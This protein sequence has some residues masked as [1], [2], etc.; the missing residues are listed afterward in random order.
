MTFQVASTMGGF[1]LKILLTV[2]TFSTSSTFLAIDYLIDL[3]VVVPNL[4]VGRP[5]L[6]GSATATGSAGAHALR[7]DQVSSL[8]LRNSLD[9]C[10][11]VDGRIAAK[12][13]LCIRSQVF[14]ITS[15]KSHHATHCCGM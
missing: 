11:K 12:Q 5:P 4:R 1:T 6:P 13:L 8:P 2:S 10:V 3:I 14:L 15:A 7:P 9:T